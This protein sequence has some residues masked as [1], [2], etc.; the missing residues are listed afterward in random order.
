MQKGVQITS[1]L[2]DF[3]GSGNKLGGRTSLDEHGNFVLVAV[4]DIL[5]GTPIVGY[6]SRL[7]LPIATGRV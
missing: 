7:R 1:N 2:D 6:R 4:H 5:T 3:H